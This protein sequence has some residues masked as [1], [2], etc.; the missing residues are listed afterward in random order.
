MR[1]F[2]SLPD[3]TGGAKTPVSVSR[4]VLILSVA[5]LI[6][7]LSSLSV[8]AETPSAA[9]VSLKTGDRFEIHRVDV[10]SGSFSLEE[11][12]D[13]SFRRE[14]EMS[15]NALVVTG[16]T[17][18][19]EIELAYTYDRVRLVVAIGGEASTLEIY[20][21]RIILD[22]TRMY[23]RSNGADIPEPI[24]TH[25]LSEPFTLRVAPNG[26]I[27]S[28]DGDS[29]TQ[30]VYPHCDLASP[31]RETW[32]RVPSGELTSDRFWTDKRN[33]PLLGGALALPATRIYR[34]VSVPDTESEP[35]LVKSEAT[36]RSDKPSSIASRIGEL[37]PLHLKVDALGPDLFRPPPA[38]V[39]ESV[40]A[41][42]TGE[43]SYR[44]DWGFISSLTQRSEAQISFLVPL[45]DS[46]KRLRKKI[47]YSSRTQVSVKK[48]PIEDLGEEVR[49]L[50]LGT[51]PPGW[52]PSVE[53]G[54]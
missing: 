8:R 13:R 7:L 15:F 48:A 27:T 21:D 51:E 33:T 16:S 26:T 32:L 49:Y 43:I 4:R 24:L 35:I 2:I 37:V 54:N 45:P 6:P 1:G 23:S 22:G 36:I 53:N 40:V 38:T 50:L 5:L 47:T 30:N 34:I 28:L 31:I 42:S 29:A 20:P 14:M 11:L 25:L 41:R 52:G 39:L 44:Q 9:Y 18:S 3:P 10:T 17:A 12:G 19:G 46:Q